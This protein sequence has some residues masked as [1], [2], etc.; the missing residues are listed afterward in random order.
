VYPLEPISPA[1]LRA[2]LGVVLAAPGSGVRA[3]AHQVSGFHEYLGQSPVQWEGLRCGPRRAPV[4]VFFALLLPGRTAIVMVPA[5][6]ELG[7]DPDE[8]L[9]VTRAGLARLGARDLHYAQALLEPGATALAALLAAAGFCPLAVLDYL[10]RDALHPWVDPPAPEEAE[11]IPYDERTHR[12]FAEI[13]LATYRDSQDCPELTGL[14]P[15]DDILAGHKASGRFEPQLWELARVDGRTA[16]CLLLAPLTHAPM[17]EVVYVGVVPECRRRGVG[18][19]LLRRAL[20]K[21]HA[22]G[23]RRLTV[24]VDDRNEPAKRLYARLG[25]LPVARRNVC[26]YRWKWVPRV[27]N[28]CT[29]PG[30]AVDNRCR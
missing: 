11:W 14:R 28:A 2:V 25:L 6:G 8:Q 21:C 24:V 22:V 15:I 3:A 27:G 12:A 29:P 17:L 10:E 9:R 13:V 7:I 20:G 18:R 30:D 26:F 4:A 19:L 5:P 16:G 1:D 23:A